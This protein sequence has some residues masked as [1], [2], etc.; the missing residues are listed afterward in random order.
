MKTILLIFWLVNILVFPRHNLN[1]SFI[2]FH[3]VISA[4]G[5]CWSTTGHA[6]MLVNMLTTRNKSLN[7]H[8]ISFNSRVSYHF[9]CN[10]PFQGYAGE[11]AFV[12]MFIHS[13]R[14]ELESLGDRLPDTRGYIIIAKNIRYLLWNRCLWR[15]LNNTYPTF[16]TLCIRCTN[17]LYD[18]CGLTDVN[19]H[20]IPSLLPMIQNVD[21]LWRHRY[22][23][24]PPAIVTS[25]W[26]IVSAWFLWTL[27]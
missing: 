1:N 18:S 3:H 26:P 5:Q 27:S 17:H 10:I 9:P 11:L 8:L 14:F 4:H 19:P 7:F 12:D 25:Q 13:C 23:S 21:L 20:S 16:L 24:R 2:K 22:K 6:A 15:S